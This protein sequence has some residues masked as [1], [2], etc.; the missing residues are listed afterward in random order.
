MTKIPPVIVSLLINYT[1]IT[2]NQTIPQSMQPDPASPT[3]GFNRIVSLSRP[4]YFCILSITLLSCEAYTKSP[5]FNNDPAQRPS[6]VFYSFDIFDK[7]VI[8]SIGNASLLII[9]FL[10]V[11]F[12]LGLLPQITTFLV[13]IMEQIDMHFFGSTS[14]TLGLKSASYSF[15]RSF[16]ATLLLYLIALQSMGNHVLFSVFCGLL[17]SMAYLL[18]RQSSNTTIAYRVLKRMI[19]ALNPAKY[20]R[21]AVKIELEAFRASPQPPEDRIQTS[22]DDIYIS[23]LKQDLIRFIC[24]TIIVFALHVTSAFNIYFNQIEKCIGILAILWGVIFH[25]VVPQLRRDI[26]FLCI[27]KPVLRPKEYNLFEVK[28]RA[29]LMWFEKVHFVAFAVE[30]NLIYPIFWLNV[31]SRDALAIR[32]LYG[33]YLGPFLMVMMGLKLI[34][35]SFNDASSNYITIIFTYLF[36]NHDIAQ[37]NHRIFT[38]NYFVFSILHLKIYELLLKLQFIYIYIAPW[39]IPWGSAFHAF[40]QPFSVPHSALLFCQAILSSI[41]SAPLQ[42]IMGSA[43]FMMSYIRPVK[44]WESDY[45]T[46]V[47]DINSTRLVTQLERNRID[48]NRLDGI[49]YEQLTK[50]LQRKLCKDL[51]LGR[52]GPV[53]QGDCFIMASDNL[54]CLVHIIELGNGLCTF[55]LRGLEFRGTYCQQ[56]EVEAIT[57]G[58]TQDDG[59]CCCKP[60]HLPHFLSANASF[61]QMWLAWHVTHTRYVIE[62]YTISDNPAG[63]MLQAFDLRK[64]LITYY[65]KAIIYFTITSQQLSNWLGTT[66]F[67]DA[68]EHT[69]DK[70]YADLDPTFSS[71]LDLDFDLGLCGVTREKFCLVYFDWINYCVHRVKTDK[72]DSA[73]AGMI[74]SL[75]CT[76]DCFLVTLCFGLSLVA[77]RSLSAAADGQQFHTVESLLFGLHALL[78][79][80]FRV[81]SL[82]DEW[83]FK[84]MR[85]FKLVVIPAVRMSL[86]LHLDHFAAP[87]DYEDNMVLYEAIAGYQK[88][89]VISH[90]TDV[91]WRSAVLTGVPTLL[92]LRLYNDDGSNQYKFIM[93][94]RRYLSFRIIKINRE[95]VRGLWASQQQELIFFQN[96]DPERGS[97]QNAKQALRNMINSSC[98]QPVGYPIYVSPLTTSYLESASLSTFLT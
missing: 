2:L 7:S 56:Q 73:R 46:N 79:G 24:S 45:N 75:E 63:P 60:G 39:Q 30:R 54:N 80:D 77:R 84:E 21:G 11:L 34:R 32:E 9:L 83:I 95:C 74:A 57:E 67:Y 64:A 88:N 42:P 25:F 23:R 86:K 48:S 87:D 51:A 26:P 93:L 92:T 43:I 89:L 37:Q 98:D 5:N 71:S 68:L 38:M 1:T 12:I 91:S 72:N 10:P 13:H 76:P 58:V 16:L 40:A 50:C 94:N 19:K 28:T 53:S 47:I 44:F 18:S 62:G 97:I 65:V 52:W 81:T 33:H 36:F 59:F 14:A 4:I 78:K 66:E 90:E 31:V 85:L 8:S 22:I 41:L 27:A 69:K 61:N 96:T 29:K 3:H 70:M 82:H 6:L 55:Q 35:S 17:V 15:A 20:E 49:F